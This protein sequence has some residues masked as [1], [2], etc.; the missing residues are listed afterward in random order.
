MEVAEQ[1]TMWLARLLWYA[2]LCFQYIPTHSFLYQRPLLAVLRNPGG[3]Y[4]RLLWTKC[5]L[6]EKLSKGMSIYI[7]SILLKNSKNQ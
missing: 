1:V 6:R 2:A 7:G 5:P 3:D 4:Q